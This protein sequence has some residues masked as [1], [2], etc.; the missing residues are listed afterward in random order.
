MARV[1]HR[2]RSDRTETSSV[3]AALKHVHHTSPGRGSGAVLKE[4]L[5]QLSSIC[6]WGTGFSYPGTEVSQGDTG[7][8][9]YLTVLLSSS[10][11]DMGQRPWAL[12]Y[13]ESDH[14]S[15][16]FFALC[17]ASTLALPLP[18]FSC[19]PIEETAWLP[20]EKCFT[21][22]R[23]P[24]GTGEI[25]LGS[26]PSLSCHCPQS[27]TGALPC[28]SNPCLLP[29]PVS[30]HPVKHLTAVFAT[31]P[32][33]QAGC[34]HRSAYVGKQIPTSPRYNF[35]AFTSVSPLLLMLLSSLPHLSI[36]PNIPHQHC[37]TD[38]TEL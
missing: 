2:R 14:I 33:L 8:M 15:L 19:F 23:Q 17:L 28:Q 35:P 25:S 24:L 6:R 34:C 38:E 21:H 18:K 11:G 26:V 1:W 31:S 9:R 7:T 3:P 10:R 37:R 20:G 32:P 30:P 36:S 29:A 16:E 22:C 13:H 4:E 27:V 12:R 5:V